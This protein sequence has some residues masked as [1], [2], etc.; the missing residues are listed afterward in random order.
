MSQLPA[1]MAQNI[2]PTDSDNFKVIFETALDA[3]KKRTK[4]SLEGHALLTRLESCDSP[5]AVLDLLRGQVNANANDGLKKW[6]NPTI[7]VLYAFSATLGEGIGLVNIKR[8][9]SDHA[10]IPMRQIFSP[11]RLIFAGIGVLLLVSLLVI[12][13]CAGPL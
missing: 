11:S 12:P 2:P 10:L 13:S 9:V 4:Q 7:N 1:S 3:Y 5:A 8:S 6:L